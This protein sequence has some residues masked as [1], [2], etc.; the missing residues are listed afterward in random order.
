MLKDILG[1]LVSSALGGGQSQQSQVGSLLESVLAS[2]GGLGGLMS[3]L[4]QGGLSDLVSSWI[5]TGENQNVS[6]S[7]IKDALGQDEIRNVAQQAGVSEDEASDLLS[8]HL[9]NVVDKLSPNGQLDTDNLDI[10]SL[11]KAAL[12]KLF[13]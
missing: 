12:G 1:S 10:E 11:A 7:Q 3:K 8:Q 4:Q 9:P 2:Q 13:S 5:G 6:A